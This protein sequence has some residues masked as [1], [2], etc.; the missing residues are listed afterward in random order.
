MRTFYMSNFLE[1]AVVS[2]L[3]IS[4]Q[5][6]L[7]DFLR[8]KEEGLVSKLSKADLN[9][10][11]LLNVKLNRT[12][13]DDSNNPYDTHPQLVAALDVL[14]GDNVHPPETVSVTP[15]KMCVER[16]DV[17][18]DTTFIYLDDEVIDFIL[19]KSN[20]GWEKPI[21]DSLL[22]NLLERHNENVVFKH[23]VFKGIFRNL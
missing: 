8:N 14:V 5:A 3:G 4:M 11:M 12:L 17:V 6:F 13:C 20:Q 10:T 9:T 7:Q 15:S 23:S 16:I 18:D 1:K 2:T 21:S 19:G 22:T